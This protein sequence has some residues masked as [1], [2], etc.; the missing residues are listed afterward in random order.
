MLTPNYINFE[1]AKLVYDKTGLCREHI[2]FKH[3]SLMRPYYT[4]KGEFNGDCLDHITKLLKKEETLLYACLEQWQLI[5]WFRLNNGIV[6]IPE[7]K[8]TNGIGLHYGVNIWKHIQD[9]EAKY[10]S[11]NIPE[12]Y[13]TPQEAYSAAFTYILNELI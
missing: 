13:A 9:V 6:I 2:G 8:H 3:G 7:V 5:E 12:N 1:Q 4:Q 11:T 10:I